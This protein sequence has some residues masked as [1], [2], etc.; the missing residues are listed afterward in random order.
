MKEEFKPS[1][2]CKRNPK[3]RLRELTSKYTVRRAAEVMGQIR[4]SADDLAS[5]SIDVLRQRVKELEEENR[6]LRGELAHYR[7]KDVEGQG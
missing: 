3:A 7:G 5:E 1:S 2:D 4:E 6:Q